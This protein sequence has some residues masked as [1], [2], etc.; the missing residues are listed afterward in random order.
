LGR[1][2]N[3]SITGF[4]GIWQNLLADDIVLTITRLTDPKPVTTIILAVHFG[5]RWLFALPLG[6]LVWFL[7]AILSIVVARGDVFL[8]TWRKR[9]NEE[10]AL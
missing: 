1:G 7:S 4:F 8:K 3:K 2:G 6:I 9:R 5:V 10:E